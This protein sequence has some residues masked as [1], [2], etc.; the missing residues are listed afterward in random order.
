M[1]YQSRLEIIREIAIN[2]GKPFKDVME[3]YTRLS[4]AVYLE[5][6]DKGL[7]YQLYTPS[8]E[9]KVAQLTEEECMK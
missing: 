8:L 6:F 4:Q 1:S 2:T 7:P 3:I 5:N 9:E